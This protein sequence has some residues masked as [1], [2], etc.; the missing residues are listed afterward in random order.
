[1]THRESTE[2]FVGAAVVHAHSAVLAA[3]YDVAV[4]GGET[5]HGMGVVLLDSDDGGETRV[6]VVEPP[7]ERA[8]HVQTSLQVATQ[9]RRLTPGDQHLA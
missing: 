1:M 5:Q 6:D 4:V 7:V 2:Q 3:R 8:R 9:Q